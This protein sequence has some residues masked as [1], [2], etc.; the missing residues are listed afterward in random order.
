MLQNP[1]QTRL[2]DGYGETIRQSITLGRVW[3]WAQN[4]A[5]IESARSVAP[6]SRHLCETGL[7]SGGPTQTLETLLGDGPWIEGVGEGRAYPYRN[8]WVLTRLSDF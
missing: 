1:R 4:W 2:S 6:Q 7:G 3:W 5:Q 8:R